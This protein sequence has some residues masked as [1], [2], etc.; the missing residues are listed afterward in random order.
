MANSNMMHVFV[1]MKYIPTDVSHLV[2]MPMFIE[3]KIHIFMQNFFHM[4][5][6]P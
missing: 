5:F 6:C 4:L 1:L 3:Q 2:F